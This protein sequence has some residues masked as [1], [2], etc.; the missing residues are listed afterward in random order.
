MVAGVMSLS[1]LALAEPPDNDN[2]ADAQ[3]LGPAVP[4]TATGTTVDSTTE[5]DEPSPI[6]ELAGSVW[7]SWTAPIGWTGNL[8][9]TVCRDHSSETSR[10]YGLNAIYT[11][12]SFLEMNHRK[13]ISGICDSMVLRPVP[14]FTYWIQVGNEVGYA[15]ERDNFTISL[16]T[17][18]GPP[19]DDMAAAQQVYGPLPKTVRGTNKGATS[20][21][22]DEAAISDYGDSVWYRIHV[23]QGGELVLD[24]CA[25]GFVP[26]AHVFDP[27]APDFPSGLAPLSHDHAEPLHVRCPSLLDAGDRTVQD[28]ETGNDYLIRVDTLEAWSWCSCVNG[29][30]SLRLSGTAVITPGASNALKVTRVKANRKKGSAKATVRLPGAGLVELLGSES[31]KSARK[32]IG[33]AKTIK[34]NVKPKGKLA[35]KLKRDG[36]AK[37][38]LK[39]RFS[40]SG[41]GGEPK[42]I[43]KKVTLKL[44]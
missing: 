8:Q 43:S 23:E 7:F 38:K 9:V 19:N 6:A 16:D 32:T 44:R 21:S 40:P 34:L 22:E 15:D 37:V 12:D 29:P 41:T 25:R 31:V 10:F 13:S 36:T 20:E 5:E 2:F 39:F 33:S 14:S 4:A 18:A 24:T 26:S 30:F 3:T 1:G 35:K 28:V 27:T 42:T 11:G 17:V